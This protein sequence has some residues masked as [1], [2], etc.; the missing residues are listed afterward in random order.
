ML[1]AMASVAQLAE[2][3]TTFARSRV[4]F[5]TGWPKVA[6]FATGPGWVLKNMRGN[7]R[8]NAIMNYAIALDILQKQVFWAPNVKQSSTL[9]ITHAAMTIFVQLINILWQIMTKSLPRT[10]LHLRWLCRH[11]WLLQLCIEA[12]ETHEDKHRSC[13]KYKNNDQMK[14]EIL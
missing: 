9:D 5:P 4:R 6:F 8:Q 14:T 12:T 13:M 10:R 1:S 2:H 11:P 3:R 7:Y